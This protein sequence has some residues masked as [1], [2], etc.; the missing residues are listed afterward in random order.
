MTT[1]GEGISPTRAPAEIPARREVAQTGLPH[2]VEADED[3]PDS[4]TVGAEAQH[5][6]FRQLHEQ[7]GR[8]IAEA[9]LVRQADQQLGAV[10]EKVTRAT[11]HVRQVKIYPPYPVDEPRRAAVIRQFNG[12]AAEIERALTGQLSP[13]VAQLQLDAG[14][15]ET[16]QAL[17]SLDQAA[18]HITASRSELAGGTISPGI[19]DGEAE[20][21]SIDIKTGFALQEKVSITGGDAD[22]LRNIG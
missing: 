3:R 10:A 21:T 2:R 7:R 22:V 6:A 15:K 5:P 11:E 12:V 20:A 16:D 19:G 1:I 8:A 9:V 14:V 4:Q 18:R 13:G 17:A